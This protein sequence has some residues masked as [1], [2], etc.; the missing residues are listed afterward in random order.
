MFKHIRSIN[1]QNANS[2]LKIIFETKNSSD[3]ESLEPVDIS[4]LFGEA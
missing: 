2:E 3:L 1:F 4:G